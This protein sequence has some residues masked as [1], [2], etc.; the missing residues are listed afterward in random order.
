ML[1][2]IILLFLLSLPLS[3]A[4]I[5]GTLTLSPTSARLNTLSQF[6]FALQPTLDI[7]ANGYILLTFSSGLNLTLANGLTCQSIYGLKD[8]AT[9][10]ITKLTESKLKIGNVFPNT[11]KY[12]MF[13]LSNLVLPGYVSTFYVE[14]ETYDASNTLLEQSSD[15]AFKFDSYPGLLTMRMDALG[16]TTVGEYTSQLKL[17]FGTENPLPASG[18]IQVK[19]PKWN[20]G[21]QTKSRALTM[22]KYAASDQQTG[23]GYNIDCAADQHPDLKCVLTVNTPSTVA[24]IS[25]TFDSLKI[26]GFAA[27]TAQLTVYISNSRFR[28]PPSTKPVTSITA[29]TFDHN[30]YEID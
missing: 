15:V 5:G 12:L 7:P 13:W 11:D 2:S 10:T 17:T 14:V 30:Q 20:A 27:Q 29:A 1:P 16:S 4:I 22:L 8:G 26:S 18:F 23:G 6:S 19:L 3:L 21:T 28:N 24:S 25:S 9:P